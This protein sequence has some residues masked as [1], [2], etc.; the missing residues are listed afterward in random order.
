[1]TAPH[2]FSL[3]LLLTA[4]VTTSI[5]TF[6]P[7]QLFASFDLSSS[8]SPADPNSL[9]HSI[10]TASP[11][12]LQSLLIE[13]GYPHASLGQR[14]AAAS[15][16]TSPTTASTSSTTKE[17]HAGSFC[18]TFVQ[19]HHHV[20]HVPSDH[21]LPKDYQVLIEEDSSIKVHEKESDGT[22]GDSVECSCDEFDCT[23]KKQ[24]FCK[25]QS[26]P[27][28]KKQPATCPVCTSCD[29][30]PIDSSNDDED[31]EGE[32][33]SPD[34]PNPAPHEFKCTC[35]FDGAGGSENVGGSTSGGMDCDCKVSDC[36][37]VRK[38][39]CRAT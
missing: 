16:T 23:C 5:T 3:L 27:F 32:E 34:K 35:S 24:C 20:V 38:C 9:Q 11:A 22:K 25:T 26:Q 10:E 13:L 17:N 37:C 6:T 39:K 19:S 4:Q 21:P 2:F 30:D 18:H 29:G 36:S 31:K 14:Q 1:M 28:P 8:D 7:E 15:P 12:D 33:G